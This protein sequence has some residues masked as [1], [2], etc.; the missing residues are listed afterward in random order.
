[1]S[2]STAFSLSIPVSMDFTLE[3]KDLTQFCLV[4]VLVLG[5]TCFPNK[6]LIDIL[7]QM[8]SFDPLLIAD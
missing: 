8:K 3:I 5:L 4:I 7:L 6:Q 2:C 1:M